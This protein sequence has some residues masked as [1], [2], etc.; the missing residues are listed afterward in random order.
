MSEHQARLERDVYDHEHDEPR[1]PAAAG[2]RSPTGAS[3]RTLF[4]QM[5]RR[6]FTALR[7]RPR[8][9]PAP[10]RPPPR[11]ADRDAGEAP[12]R[13]GAARTRRRIAA[14][15]TR[16]S[17]RRDRADARDR[18]AVTA[19]RDAWTAER[20]S[21]AG[22]GRARPGR[23]AAPPPAAADA[24]G[25]GRRAARRPARRTVTISGRPEGA[26]RD[27]AVPRGPAAPAPRARSPSAWAPRPE[28]LAAW[29]FAL[30]MLL[31]LIAILDRRLSRGVRGAPDR[32]RGRTA[33]A[34]RAGTSLVAYTYRA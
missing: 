18:G 5:P 33:S 16:A 28:R 14:I 2:A 25:R 17:A 7:R 29:A 11:E 3:A 34:G 24:A 27:A 23:D 30:G 4:E 1:P 12:A 9:A 20:R 13:I 10:E 31:I 21:L 32:E 22:R 15:A 8:G 6:R 19:D 26:R